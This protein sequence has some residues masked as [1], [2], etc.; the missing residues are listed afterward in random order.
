MTI[1]HTSDWHLGHQLYGYDRTEEQASMLAQI[2]RIVQARQPDALLVS[3]DV[4]DN[5]QPSAAAQRMFAE[6]I[7]R[8]HTACPTMC[9]VVT[10]GNHDSGVRHEVFRTPWLALGVHV[11]GSVSKEDVARHIVE[12]S[13]RGY[14]IAVPYAYERSLPPSFF[15]QALDEVARRNS[16]GLPVVLMAHTTVGGCDFRGHERANATT[17]GGIDAL[18]LEQ[19]GEGFDYLALGHIHHAQF[20]QGGGR[21]VRYSGTPL[22]VSFDETFSHSVSLVD[23][24]RH[25]AAP[26]V[27][28][29]DIENPRP[30]VTLPTEGA[31][32]LGV[33]LQLLADFP[34]DI[35]A[36][37]RLNVAVDD[38]LPTE[39]NAEAE[40]FAKGKACRFC[41]INATRE[42]H[43]T[44]TEK[45][46][47]VAE[48][49]AE[50]PLEIAHRYAV[51]VGFT[52]DAEMDTLFHE[53][54]AS[55]AEERRNGEGRP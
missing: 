13:G 43:R 10:A 22:A 34:S 29:I 49:Q 2:E 4:F 53:A 42:R 1:L 7:V 30:L 31:A 26:Q 21:R 39:A 35:P 51:D 6:S 28:A 48:F 20:V 54:E 46:L 8:M 23:I 45:V 25:G 9:I 52:F 11:V 14:V 27:E 41:L 55:V 24:A 17:V 47:T 18:P 5:A 44:E 36:Y 12:L 40:R 37:I 19:L 50:S 33:C 16:L 32:P 15:Q 3:G 38:F